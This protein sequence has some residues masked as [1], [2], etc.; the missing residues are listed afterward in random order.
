MPNKKLLR[1]RKIAVLATD[2]FEK[3]ELVAPV[4]ALKSAGALIEIVSLHLG[5]IRGVNLHEPAGKIRVDR[6]IHEVKASDYDGL[7]IPGG[8]MN[9]DLLRQSAEVRD[10]VR[11]FDEAGKPI[12]SICHGPWVLASAGLTHGRTLT[13]WPGVRD[14][15]VHAGAV[16]QDEAVVKSGNWVTSRGPQDLPEFIAALIPQFAHQGPF[17]KVQHRLTLVSAPQRN[18]PPEVMMKAISWMP[19]PSIRTAVGLS[20]VAAGA[21]ALKKKRPDLNAQLPHIG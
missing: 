18:V 10:F 3:I 5:S 14:D 7:F 1:N 13:S 8:L 6:V 12:A 9:P 11:A 17:A 16:W 20:V 19:R 15:L 4:K 21:F 2:G